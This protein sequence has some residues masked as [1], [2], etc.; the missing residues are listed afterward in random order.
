MLKLSDALRLAAFFQPHFEPVC[1]PGYC[2]VAGG[3]R[4][5]KSY[6]HD[7]E[8][9][10]KPLDTKPPLLFGIKPKDQPKTLLDVKLNELVQ[11][12]YL[13][14]KQGA[15]RNKK[16]YVN[17]AKFGI[18]PQSEEGSP[19]SDLSFVLDLWV[20]VSPAQF[21]VNLAIR[22]GPNS[23]NNKFSKWIVTP[24]SQ[25]GALP[26]GYRVKYAAVWRVDQF[27][28][29]T[30]ALID[31]ELP[32]AMPNE[33]DFLLNLLGLHMSPTERHADWGRYTR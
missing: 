10:L 28:P 33:Y 18:E 14:F 11:A 26:D 29:G 13:F 7:L 12:E 31:G 22:T 3:T 27:H 23:E 9:V 19:E 20:T 8:F 2:E 15:D 16:Y 1:E 17:M 25:G 4:R 21:G 32:F 6:V 5:E 30:D 24:R